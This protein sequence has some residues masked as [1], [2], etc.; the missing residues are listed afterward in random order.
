MDAIERRRR[1]QSAVV[2]GDGPAVITLVG[3]GPTTEDPLQLIGDG[4]LIALV[5]KVA[6]AAEP[7]VRCASLLRDRSWHGDDVLAQQLTAAL[8]EPVAMGLKPLPIDLDDLA[9][10]LEGD[11]VQG[12]GRIDLR[13]GEIWHQATIDYAREMGEEDEDDSD[14]EEHWLWA[15]CEGSSAAFR[16]MEMFAGTITDTRRAER[17]L[18]ALE[19]RGPFRRFR[20]VLAR[21]PEDFTAGISS[22]T[23]VAVAEAGNGSPAPGTKPP[24]RRNRNPEALSPPDRRPEREAVRA[25][26]HP[27]IR[28]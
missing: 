25:P 11:P 18:E 24:R 15:H 19:A 26:D 28:R 2:R 12:G 27:D 4:L 20:D 10:I 8:G 22:P 5:Q 14:D 7:T 6:G 3:D 1:L 13:T 17:L 9:D 16:D 21:W 23:N